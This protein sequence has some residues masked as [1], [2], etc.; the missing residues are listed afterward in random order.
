MYKEI[1]QNCY[2][3]FCIEHDGKALHSLSTV[4]DTTPN[5]KLSALGKQADKELKEYFQGKRKV[6][7]LPLDP[8]LAGFTRTACLALADIP[9][10]QTV[11]YRDLAQ[12]LGKPKA[13]RAIGNA[14]G[15]NPLPILLPCH[16]V[17][18]TDGNLG[19]F[20]LGLDMKRDLLRLEGAAWRE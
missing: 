17:I 6:F 11:S 13:C 18:R 10:G 5:A 1:I 3:I 9:Y 20:S 14:I 15:K 19:G 4:C 7:T 8:Q 2:G 12:R 16:R